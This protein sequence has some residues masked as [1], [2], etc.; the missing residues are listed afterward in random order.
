MRRHRLLAGVLAGIVTG[1]LLA[2][3]DPATPAQRAASGPA[4]GATA[5]G[6][7]ATSTKRVVAAAR[8]LPVALNAIVGG[9]NLSAPGTAE[10]AALLQVGLTTADPSGLRSP[11]ISQAA[12]TVDNGL[13]KVLPDGS[14]EMTFNLRPDVLWHDGTLFTADDIVFTAAVAQNAALPI[15]RPQIYQYVDRV[16][17]PDAH[18]VVVYWKQPYIEADTIFGGGDGTDPLPKHLLAEAVQTPDTFTD[19]P[20][21]NRAFVGTGPYRLKE[22]VAESHAVVVANPSYHLGKPP[23]DT[24]E[25]RFLSD[26]NTMVA[27]VLAGSLD[28]TMGRGLSL[29]QGLEIQQQWRGGRVDLLFGGAPLT[30]GPQHRVPEPAL[31]GD[32]AFRRAL[33][34]AINRQEIVDTL[35]GG[36]GQVA[37]TPIPPDNHLMQDANAGAVRYPFDPRRAAQ[38][39]EEMGLTRGPDGAFRDPTGAAFRVELRQSGA[40][41]LE[42][43]TILA[44]AEGWNRIGVPSDTVFVPP[45]RQRDREYRANYPGFEAGTVGNTVNARD[46]SAFRASE[47]RTPERSYQGNNRTGYVN[48][49]LE[50]LVDRYVVTIPIPE[51]KQVLTQVIHQMTDQVVGMYL[52]FI[53][54]YPTAIS[55]HLINVDANSDIPVSWNA[56]EWDLK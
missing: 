19:Q 9:P 14:M 27:N 4:S 52:M 39:L 8:G 35:L 36:V 25:V 17:A 12:P 5:A 43:K 20:Y 7:Q 26:Y 6:S 42:Q 24:I 1:A 22:W 49:E 37:D 13:W 55:S 3:C 53:V 23:I 33:Y 18:T 56:H 51:R 2:A 21:W 29:E 31:I 41:D 11:R 48:S 10:L 15:V 40:D 34:T 47:L 54:K 45:A 38:Q 16:A 46:L 44:V 32:A 50:A 28:L 30:L